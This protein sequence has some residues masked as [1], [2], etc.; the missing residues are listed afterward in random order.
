MTIS[1]QYDPPPIPL[2]HYDWSA[3]DDDTY[4]VDLDSYGVPVSTSPIGYG[5]TEQEAV[6]NLLDQTMVRCIHCADDEVP[7]GEA[8]ELHP[9]VW[10]CASC[11]RQ[12]G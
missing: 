1:T 9:D 10:G 2:R 11:M 3:I 7:M 8:E 6:R 12:I 5:R 4:D